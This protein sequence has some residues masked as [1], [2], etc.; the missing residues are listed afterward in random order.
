MAHLVALPLT[1]VVGAGQLSVQAKNIIS[2]QCTASVSPPPSRVCSTGTRNSMFGESV[3]P[4][5]FFPF[6]QPT[7]L[8]PITRIVDPDP[9]I[10][11]DP[12]LQD[13][14]GSG[15]PQCL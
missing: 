11:S 10:S 5:L 2:K 3:L 12:D 7:S 1:R 4:L 6:V 8:K 9:H 15:S 13:G 14:K